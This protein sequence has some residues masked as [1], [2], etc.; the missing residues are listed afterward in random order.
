MKQDEAATVDVIESLE[1]QIADAEHQL[2]AFASGNPDEEK[3]R[4]KVLLMH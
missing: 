1:R 2:S 3:N 4:I